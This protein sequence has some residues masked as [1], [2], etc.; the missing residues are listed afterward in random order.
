MTISKESKWWVSMKDGRRF[1]IAN[2]WMISFLWIQ[3]LLQWDFSRQTICI[4]L[5][6]QMKAKIHSLNLKGLTCSV[7][8]LR[9]SS[10]NLTSWSE[11]SKITT[12]VL[13][14][15]WLNFRW[16]LLISNFDSW[17]KCL[18]F[19]C[20]MLMILRYISRSRSVCYRREEVL[21]ILQR[22]WKIT[23]KDSSPLFIK[24]SLAK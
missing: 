5:P 23:S 8:C 21:S 11:W 1:S 12:R 9:W 10:R 19:R 4:T 3:N 15:W 20:P 22:S 6:I 7:P 24:A 13:H 2:G 14:Q 18:R 17:S 16:A